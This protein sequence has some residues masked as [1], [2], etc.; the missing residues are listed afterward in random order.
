VFCDITESTALGERADPEIL[1]ELMLDYYEQMRRV[2]ERHGGRVEKFIGDAVAA[3]WGIPVT[4]EDDAVRAVRAALEMTVTAETLRPDF[5]AATELGFAVRVGVST[6][7]VMVS[8][9]DL[10]QAAAILGDAMNTAA[11]L[12]A[13]AGPGEVVIA[14][15]T[16]R[17]AGAAVE[18]EPAME[19]RLKGK[20]RPVAGHRVRAVAATT[21]DRGARSGRLAG[22]DR[23]L[24]LL[25]AMLAGVAHGGGCRLTLVTG[26]AGVGKS[27]LTGEFA[28]RN[29]CRMLRGRCLSYG[30]G[31]AFWPLAEI[32]RTAA[33]IGP[34]TSP[35]NAR[36]L[37]R[38]LVADDP[39]AD[40]LA[41]VIA[42]IAGMESDAGTASEV[43]WATVSLLR[44]LAAREGRLVICIDDMQWSQRP[45]L[46]LILSLP[47]ELPEAPVLVV[48]LARPEVLERHS[49][50]PNHLRVELL[51]ADAPVALVEQ[52]WPGADEGVVRGIAGRAGGNPLFAEELVA[53]LVTRAAGG[54]PAAD[55]TSLPDSLRGLL[56]ARLDVLPPEARRVAACGAVEGEVFH[57][58]AVQAMAD[59]SQRVD[60]DRHM[61]TLVKSGMIRTDR[62]DQPAT[63][64]FHHLLVRDALYAAT[65]KRDRSDLHERL[66]KW[67]ASPEGRGSTGVAAVDAL[68][69]YHL[70][71]AARL[72]LEIAP[73]RDHAPLRQQ[74]STHLAA[75]GHRARAIGD[76]EAA[77]SLYQRARDV[78]PANDG[79][80]LELAPRLAEAVAQTGRLDAAIEVVQP[81]LEAARA[82]DD[83]PLA[84][85]CDLEVLVIRT[86]RG[87]PGA[88]ELAD[89]TARRAIALL[90]PRRDDTG[91]A[92]AWE[93]VAS[94]ALHSDDMGA[95]AD[96]LEYAAQHARR[97]GDEWQA[98][99]SF[100]W[101]TLITWLRPQHIS[102]SLGDVGRISRQAGENRMVVAASLITKGVLHAM[103]GE[104]DRG[105]AECALGR[106]IQLALGQRVAWSG[107]VLQ[108]GLIERLAGDYAAAEALYRASV[109][110]P[111]G[112]PS[113]QATI[114][115]HLGHV[116]YVQGRLDDADM[117][118]REGEHNPDKTD[119]VTVCMS[120]WLRALLLARDG[121]SAGAVAHA[122]EAVGMTDARKAVDT[123]IDALLALAE[124]QVQGRE[125]T[126]A[127]AT[128]RE[129]E[130][131]VDERGYTALR[132]VTDGLHARLE[133][134]S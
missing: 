56:G 65:P 39:D 13:A 99:E 30:E 57:R 38:A 124:V 86:L 75:A 107:S 12:Q 25:D 66:A 5:E 23:E 6:G 36:R 104:P 54:D 17:L 7:E 85:R 41:E 90:T 19:L 132:P 48:C 22:R 105:R 3:V 50:W 103:S 127:V 18:A 119:V 116:L 125:R 122:L 97:A 27:R 62:D 118:C 44:H 43:T 84:A 15:L 24:A 76:V 32:I 91:L 31:I 63:Y 21:A 20:A 134:S 68:A 37:I 11:R 33:G 133:R 45:L 2:V 94:V 49:V 82:I 87:D 52:L 9:V 93:V 77:S 78:L 79:G 26:E 59:P 126:Q 114:A 42:Q 14:Q 96:A 98:M 46:D 35:E 55:Q 100:Y 47:S 81:A 89:A 28:L 67:I 1:R 121:D 40:R 95:M 83:L 72:R 112:A 128:L 131:L 101:L 8:P 70:E 111:E 64:R 110:S 108:A 29:G 80:W 88:A 60:L 4:G 115:L 113:F 117:L 109:G 34:E 58:P 102:R 53:M 10:T 51:D 120:K 92:R 74:A 69:G 73:R 16:R 129:L 123:R 130:L 61:A 71:Q 106:E